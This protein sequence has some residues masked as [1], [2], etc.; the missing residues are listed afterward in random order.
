MTTDALARLAIAAL[1]I[2]WVIGWIAAARDVKRTRWREPPRTRALHAIPIVLCAALL[3]APRWLPPVF[4]ARFAPA[5]LALPL[6]DTAIVALGLGFAGWARWHIG[7][8]WSGWVTLKD[9]HALV[10]TGPYGIVRHPIYTGLLLALAGT[11]LA[12]GEWR[13]ILAFALAALGFILKLRI[14]EARMRETFPE[15]ERYRR[16]VAA[17]IPFV[18]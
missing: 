11:A 9:D 16:R 5:G 7:R 15:Y 18:F 4:T 2:I 13:G 10:C 3:M 6:F 12:I 8:N 17:L 14:E 1:W